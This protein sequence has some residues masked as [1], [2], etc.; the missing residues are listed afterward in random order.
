[1]W[2]PRQTQN[3]ITVSKFVYT[4]TCMYE[5]KIGDQLLAEVRCSLSKYRMRKYSFYTKGRIYGLPVEADKTHVNSQK[6]S[7]RIYEIYGVTSR[8]KQL[9][10]KS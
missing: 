1:M 9:K 3:F 8:S 6:I 5:S 7:C 10:K 2:T 4:W